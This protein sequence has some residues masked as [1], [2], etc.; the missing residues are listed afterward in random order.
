M[1][2]YI[3]FMENRKNRKNLGILVSILMISAVLLSGCGL[4]ASLNDVKDEWA[5]SGSAEQKKSDEMSGSAEKKIDNTSEDTKLKKSSSAEYN[6]TCNLGEDGTFKGIAANNVG[7]A[8]VRETE[9]KKLGSLRS[10]GMFK[11]VYLA[12][13]NKK[14]SDITVYSTTMTLIDT[15]GHKYSNSLEAEREVIQNGKTNFDVLRA[16]QVNSGQT[17]VGVAVFEIPADAEIA[18]LRYNEA[19]DDIT[20]EIPFKVKRAD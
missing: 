19:T 14:K 6:Y 4:S 9:Q 1:E 20:L 16:K 18:E 2:W 11:V 3:L 15:N 17:I 8:I 13:T 12:V 10:D 5:G 7:M